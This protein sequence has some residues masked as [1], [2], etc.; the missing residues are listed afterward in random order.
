MGVSPH[1]GFDRFPEQGS[2]LGRRVE[3]CFDYDTTRT[4]LGR[5]VRDDAGGDGRMIILLD[6]GRAVLATE[7]QYH[8]LPGDNTPAPPD[9]HDP[10]ARIVALETALAVALDALSR[11]AAV[12]GNQPRIGRD[13]ATM[14]RIARELRDE[15]AA[16]LSTAAT[17]R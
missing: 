2:F 3:V 12:I 9:T 16:V 13:D 14:A 7:C 1:V 8:P 17:E 10:G 15:H 5:C 6:D 4:I 11:A